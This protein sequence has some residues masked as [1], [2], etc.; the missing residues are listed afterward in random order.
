M[1]RAEG[2]Q[3]GA[4]LIVGRHNRVHGELSPCT[5]WV[6]EV[7]QAFTLHTM[8]QA[9]LGTEEAAGNKMGLSP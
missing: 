3:D 8:C 9:V 1:P 5:R 6:L 7:S 4:L 2:Q